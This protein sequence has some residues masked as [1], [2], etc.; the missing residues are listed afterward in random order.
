[1]KIKI[2]D[3]YQIAADSMNYILQEKKVSKKRRC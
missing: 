1:M 3:K 2:D